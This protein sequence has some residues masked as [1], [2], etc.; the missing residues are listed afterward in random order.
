MVE[1]SVIIPSRNEQETI[2]DCIKKIRK[3]LEDIELNAEIIVADNSEDNTPEIAR[4][5]GADVITPDGRGYGYAYKYAFKYL[6][7]KH[8]SYPKYVVIGDADGT[9][10]FSEI[11]KLLEPLMKGEADLVI[12][13]RFKGKIEK[14]AMPWY[15]RWI[16]NPIL[17][18][19]LNLFY[20]VGVSDAHSG[21]RAI[22]GEALN[23]I[24]IH[25]NGMEFASEMLIEA[26]RKGLRI[27]EVPI[28]YRRRV[29]GKSKLSSLQDGWR[30]LK[31]MLTYAPKHLYMYP[32]A[33]FMVVGAILLLS[34]LFRVNLG[35]SPGVHTSIAGSLLL[36]VGFQMLLFGVFTKMLLGERLPKFL[37]LER[38]ST[39]G[40]LIFM[41]GFVGA[42]KI[43][44]DWIMSGFE[45]LPPAV[46]SVTCLTLMVLGLQA[47]LSSFLMSV[48]AEKKHKWTP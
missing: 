47:F 31:F 11:P 6:K 14:G 44:L 37:S 16:G 17:T 36:I 8:G 34:A 18:M 45:Y 13:S 25:S 5:L 4:S 40:S 32:G 35:Y 39:I 42:A 23:K 24:E 27:A 22:R 46:Y 3:A 26:A 2:G 48:I 41:A 20:K 38:S 30:H 7:A 28:T 1:V 29:Y 9:Y 21:F 12:G 10:D 19:F 33:F 15:R 43:G